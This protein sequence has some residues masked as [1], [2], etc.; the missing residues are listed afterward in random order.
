MSKKLLSESEVRRFMKLA[1][2]EPL[3]ETF[4][5][6]ARS[7]SVLREQLDLE[8]EELPGDEGPADED[9]PPEPGAGPE[10]EDAPAGMMGMDEELSLIHI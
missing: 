10:G 7:G 1:T 4:V 5:D 6:R 2:I 9:F 3:T 8:D